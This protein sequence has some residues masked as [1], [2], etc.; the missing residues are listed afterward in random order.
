MLVIQSD[1]EV[2]QREARETPAPVGKRFPAI[3]DVSTP[4]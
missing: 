2:K 1:G 4:F 3:E